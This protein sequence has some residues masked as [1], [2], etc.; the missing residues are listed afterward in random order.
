MFLT[1]QGRF[2]APLLLSVLLSG[3]GGSAMTSSPKPGSAELEYF[4]GQ[5]PQWRLTVAEGQIMLTVLADD[6]VHLAYGHELQPGQPFFSPMVAKRSFTGPA[7]VSHDAA[8]GVLT[9]PAM[10][11][12]LVGS[13]WQ[14]DSKTRPLT[15][16]CVSDWDDE[17]MN[18]TLSR[19]GAQDIYGL[20]QQ[21]SSERQQ[22]SWLGLKRESPSPFGNVMGYSNIMASGDTQVPVAYVVGKGSDG[23]GLF[24]DSPY[25]LRFGFDGDEWTVN[26]ADGRLGLM[27]FGGQDLAELR[28]DYLALTGTP[29]VP[30]LKAFGL[31]ISEYGYDNWQ[32]LDEKL[33]SLRNVGIPVDG[34]VLDL[35]WYGGVVKGSEYT[36]AGGL[37]WDQTNY[38][39]PRQKLAEYGSSGIGIMLIE[40]SYIGAAQ[41]VHHTLAEQRMLAMDCPSPCT[42]ATRLGDN[43]WWG[44]GGMLDWSNPKA[45]EFWHDR[46]RAPLINDGILGHWTDLGEPEV[47]DSNALYAGFDWYGETAQGHRDIHNLY[48]FLWSQGIA[49]NT[50]RS[51]GDRR[52]WIL[53]RSGTAG[54]Q[55]FG[56]ALW[57]GD[58]ASSF[59]ALAAHPAA[60]GNMSLSGFDYYGSDIGGFHRGPYRSG[61]VLDSLYTRWL[62][63]SVLSDIPLRP[64]ANNLCNC[65]QT[66]PDQVGDLASNKANLE[67]RYRLVP[68][69]YSLAHQAWANGE[70]IFPPLAYHFPRDAGA[71]DEAQTRMVGP[72]LATTAII[73]NEAEVSSYLPPGRWLDFHQPQQHRDGGRADV[74][75]ARDGILM[76]PLYLREGAIVPLLAEAPAYLARTDD[77]SVKWFKPLLIRTLPVSAQSQ[78]VMIEDD[79]QSRGYQRGLVARTTITAVRNNDRSY[80]L[81]LTPANQ[82]GAT[83][84]RQLSIEVLGAP[85]LPSSVEVNGQ[86]L[87]P[88]NA[89]SKD[90]GWFASAGGVTVQLGEISVD[91]QQ[92]L[93]IR[94]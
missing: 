88:I 86:P 41:P 3:C 64:H 36:P 45:R 70:A 31:W 15:R 6:L 51:H 7:T 12:R 84:S 8:A 17:E 44:I 18:L 59:A 4:D 78:F 22:L 53:S 13:C 58:V 90:R 1:A 43:P 82:T 54:S 79:G 11:I 25:A 33:A 85:A 46:K 76:A 47:Y 60:Q 39:N 66:T 77:N 5:L 32:E 9:T 69:L 71:R 24:V 61:P 30:P 89:A 93:V 23:Y 52:P 81:N 48:N 73:D 92:T 56:V 21:L 83:A 62:A 2:A 55:R 94:P 20:G 57:S 49:E 19:E 87:L 14:V 10:T 28:R 65:T 72:W 37:T 75:V 27:L 38:P 40:Q 63:N 80:Q 74:A 34:A 68:Y 16:I 35:Q 91:A 67:L 42:T 50:A 26:S 29:P